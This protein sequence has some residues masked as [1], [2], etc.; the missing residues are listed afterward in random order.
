MDVIGRAAR[1]RIGR[2]RQVIGTVLGRRDRKHSTVQE[3]IVDRSPRPADLRFLEEQLNGYNVRSTSVP[4]GGWI[5]VF[6]RDQTSTIVAGVSAWMWGNCLE[7]TYL[8]VREDLRGK[9]YG[10]RLLAAVEREGLARDCRLAL[11]NTFSFQAPAF[12]HKLGYS[13]FGTV[14][15]YLD[16]CTRYYLRKTLTKVD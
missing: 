14:D 11:L 16:G 12:Y 3:M 9:G 1:R 2:I 7:I 10:R 6:Y 13:T 5:A 4:Y 15:E 8:W